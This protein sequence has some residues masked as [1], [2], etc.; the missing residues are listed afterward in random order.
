MDVRPTPP[1]GAW[2]SWWNGEFDVPGKSGVRRRVLN[3]CELRVLAALVVRKNA[4]TGRVYA[5]MDDLMTPDGVEKITKKTDKKR[6]MRLQRS[7]LAGLRVLREIGILKTVRRSHGLTYQFQPPPAAVFA[8]RAKEKLAAKLPG[9]SKT[10]K[11]CLRCRTG[12]DGRFCNNRHIV[13]A[14]TAN[15]AFLTVMRNILHIRKVRS[16][17]HQSEVSFTSDVKTTRSAQHGIQTFQSESIQKGNF[18]I[19]ESTMAGASK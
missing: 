16:A 11:V 15:L 17:S 18:S 2:E 13:A 9:N 5:I 10:A 14:E 6:W 8:R 1:W 19:L 4:K 12:H 7:F 3:G